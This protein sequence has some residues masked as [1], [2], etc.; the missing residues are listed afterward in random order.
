VSDPLYLDIAES[1][2]KI[3]L[4]KGMPPHARLPSEARLVKKFGAAR[5]T[6]RRALAK[7]REEKLVYSR[8]AVGTFVAEARIDQDLDQLVSFSEFMVYSGLVPG[9]RILEAAEQTIHDVESPVLLRLQ[10]QPGSKVIFLRRLRLG[11]GEPLVIA[12]TWLPAVLFPGFI[13]QDLKRHSVYEIMTRMGHRPIDAVQTIES[14]TLPEEEANLLEVA[15]GSPALLI[16]RLAY[17]RGLPVEYA[18]DHYRGDRTAFRVRLGVLEQRLGP[19][20]HVI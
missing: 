11:S 4:S 17:S 10:L 8:P 14:I 6:V 3:I 19:E 12:N 2:R 7:L 18:V 20:R 13:K 15:A 5:A 9:T 1:I 16:R